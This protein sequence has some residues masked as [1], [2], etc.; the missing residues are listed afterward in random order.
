MTQHLFDD[1]L[2]AGAVGRVD[3]GIQQYP[4]SRQ[5]LRED[6][7]DRLRLVVHPDPVA[8]VGR[9]AQASTQFDRHLLL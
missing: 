2:E 1:P 6:A 9:G 3:V 5:R 4:D 8:G 7:G